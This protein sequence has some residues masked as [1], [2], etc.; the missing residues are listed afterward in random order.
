MPLAVALRTKG[1]SH[2]CVMTLSLPPTAIFTIL[3][4]LLENIP[5]GEHQMMKKLKFFNDF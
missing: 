5:K 3:P 2:T 4:N 1:A